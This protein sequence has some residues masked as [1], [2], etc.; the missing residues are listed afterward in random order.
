MAGTCSSTTESCRAGMALYNCTN[1]LQGTGAWLGF[2]VP[3]QRAA[4]QL[5]SSPCRM[6]VSQKPPFVISLEINLILMTLTVLGIL[7]RLWNLSYPPAVVFDEV[8]YG[9]FISLYMKR[10]FFLDDSGPPLGHM[11][12]ALGGYLGGFNGDYTWNRIGAEYNSNVPV[13]S[14]RLLPAVSG[15]LCVPLA[16]QIV[17]E[18]GF[19]VWAGA[20]AA[21]LVLFENALITQSRL[22]LLESVLIFF[23]LLAVLSYLKF[24]S[25]QQM[26][27]FSVRWWFWLILTGVSCSL[28]V[29]VKYTG[30]FSYLLILGV[31]GVHSW[32]LIG[33]RTLS[34]ISVV[35][36]LGARCLALLLVPAAFYLGMFYVHLSIL[37][38]SG[39]HDHIMSSAFQASLEG[40]LA[41]ITQGQPLEV[42]FGSQI[43]LR[44]TVGKPVPCWLHSH[45]NTYPIMYEGGRGSSHQQQVTCYPYKDVNNW[46]IVKDPTRQEMVVSSPPR[47]VRHGDTVQLVHGM[48][49]RFLNTHDVAAPFSPYA[50]E[51]SCYIDYNVSMPAQTLWKVEIVN[52]ETDR[53]TWKTILSEVKLVHVN[54]SAALKL[55]GSALPDWGYRQLE[56]VGDKLAKTYHPSLVWNVE[57]HRY[58]KSQEQSELEQEL[59]TPAQMDVGRNLSFMARF[60]ELQWKILTMRS[61]SPEHKYSSSPLAWVTLDTSIAYWLHPKS[62]AQIQL[63]GNPVIWYSA[64]VGVAVYT[65]LLLYYLLRRRRAIYDIPQGSWQALQLTGIL[66]LGG[67]AVNYLPFFLMEKTLFLYHYLPALTCQILLL[68]PLFEHTHQHLIRSDALQNTFSAL[69]LVWMS[70]VVLTYSKL[71]PLTYGDPPLSPAEL[72][73]LRWK[74]TWDILIR[75]Q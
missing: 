74:D 43:T 55:S 31:A 67:W 23:I 71:S 68:P 75:K 17:V 20:A 4:E 51:I 21:V 45:K 70:S 12:L 65:A 34:N 19:S 73:S 9:Q 48:T 22:M 50:Q 5:T 29:G 66:C 7:S 61:D 37:T 69:L 64:N 6:S 41:R 25:Y 1:V 38:R 46:W 28:A 36:H 58:G 35:V 40:G 72:K 53:D 16:Y 13:W 42:V 27:P 54:T 39:P 15:G 44:N 49:A 18:L 59:H 24:H 10:I 3:R 47:A 56:V 57:E 26:S 2:V 33:D 63:L 32:Q 8:Y 62:T 60:W 14:L 30:L 52:R 11:L